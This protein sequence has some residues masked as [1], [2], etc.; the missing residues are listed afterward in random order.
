MKGN[1][2]PQ[3][4]WLTPVSTRYIPRYCRILSVDAF[5]SNG[6]IAQRNSYKLSKQGLRTF[7]YYLDTAHETMNHIQRLCSSHLGL[8]F[9]QSTQSLESGLDLP[10]P[11]QFFCKFLCG[12]LSHE[13][14]VYE[15][16]LTDPPL[17][18]LLRSQGKHRKQFDHYFYDHLRHYLS[19]WNRRI[20]L[21]TLQEL[22][23]ALEQLEKSIVA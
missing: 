2:E 1:Y 7:H 13:R 15:S 22:P 8:F 23:Q 19:G 20:D 11:Q 14:C 21:Q 4:A 3:S 9:P 10:L 12:T 6:T 5:P 18:D 16:V 17:F